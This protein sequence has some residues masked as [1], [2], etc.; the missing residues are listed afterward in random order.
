MGDMMFDWLKK[1]PEV[2]QEAPKAPRKLL[3]KK[4]NHTSVS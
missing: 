4:A 3:Q 1:K 2:K